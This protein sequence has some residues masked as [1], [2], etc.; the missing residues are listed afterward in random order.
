LANYLTEDSFMPLNN[1]VILIV[2]PRKTMFAHEL[3]W[4]IESEGGSCVIAQN[5]DSAIHRCNTFTFT[6][7]AVHIAHA[8]WALSIGVPHLV[9]GQDAS[10]SDIISGLSSLL[11]Q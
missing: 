4:S 3:C 7:A 8:A 6:A 11:R 2:D 9:Y 10:S 1:V 5:I